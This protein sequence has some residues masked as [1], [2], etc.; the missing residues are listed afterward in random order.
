[1]K[2]KKARYSLKNWIFRS[3][4]IRKRK[5]FIV[6]YFLFFCFWSTLLKITP[7]P[8]FIARF[9]GKK[10]GKKLMKN[11]EKMKKNEEK[12]KKKPKKINEKILKCCT[13][14]LPKSFLTG[15]RESGVEPFLFFFSF[16]TF[17][18]FFI[19][20]FDVIDFFSLWIR[21]VKEL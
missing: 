12:E 15:E 18:R 17:V 21:I 7:S 9:I 19:Y 5:E 14:I 11:E 4:F 3:F 6:F 20:K 2:G 10:N 1:M 16:L 13:F 8:R